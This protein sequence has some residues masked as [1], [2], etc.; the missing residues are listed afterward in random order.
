MDLI[1]QLVGKTPYVWWHTDEPTAESDAPFY[2]HRIPS[3]EY[4]QAA[5]C[6]CAGLV[7][8]LQLSRGL[9]IPG[10]K[11]KYYYAGGTFAWHQYLNSIGALECVDMQK[12]YPAGSL[13]LRRYRNTD[14]Q[15]HLAVLY[16]S[17]KLSEQKLLH[18]YSKVGITIDDAVATSHAWDASGYYEFICPNWFYAEFTHPTT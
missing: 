11:T 13:L 1:G 8:L 6:N 16:T 12:E 4:I 3:I 17:G 2:C 15:G 9:P 14:D 18:C 5:G 7:N 10:M